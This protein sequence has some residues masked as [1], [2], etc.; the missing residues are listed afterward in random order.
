MMNVINSLLA[1]VLSVAVQSQPVTQCHQ[2]C[3]LSEPGHTL[4]SNFEGYS[5]FIYKDAAGLDTIGIG[6]LI[7]PGEKFKEPLLPE[8]AHKLLT[9]DATKASKAVN[10]R[11]IVVLR[12]PQADALISFTFNLGE[13]SLAKSTL[14]KRVNAERHAEVPAEFLKWV[15][16]GGVTL[17]GLVTRRTAE[18][19]FYKSVSN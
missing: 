17:A 1:S 2:D 4:V 7:L 14:L 3:R 15:K 6:H 10:R 9:K 12:Q 19:T 18:A 11:V 8:D 16:A 5:P 13:G